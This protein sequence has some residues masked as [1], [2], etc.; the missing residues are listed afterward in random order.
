MTVE[1]TPQDYTPVSTMSLRDLRTEMLRRAAVM[2]ARARTCRARGDL[3]SARAYEAR[4][5]KMARVARSV[6]VS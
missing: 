1:A 5:E 2:A 6:N 3:R 4:A